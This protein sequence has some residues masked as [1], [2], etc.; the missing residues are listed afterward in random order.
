MN[1]NHFISVWLCHFYKGIDLLPDLLKHTGHIEKA[2]CRQTKAGS[3]Q[4][5][6]SRYVVLH[7]VF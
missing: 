5:R 2:G 1:C 4:A 6:Y 3:A 7:P